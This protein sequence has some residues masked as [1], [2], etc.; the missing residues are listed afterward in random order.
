MKLEHI[1]LTINSHDEIINF[2]HNVLDMK[3]V[4][5]FTLNSELANAIFNINMGVHVYLLKKGNLMLEVFVSP[6]KISHGFNHICISVS[7]RELFI[8]NAIKRK[9]EVIQIEREF[10]NLVFLKDKNGNAFEI[11]E[12]NN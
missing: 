3:T 9:Y 5:A 2:Y 10:N 1:A 7:N 8:Q 11:K 4:K 12:I 6:K